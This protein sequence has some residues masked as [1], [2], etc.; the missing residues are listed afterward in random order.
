MEP[1]LRGPIG[2]ETAPVVGS[3]A[4]V[5]RRLD[6]QA[7]S[8][9]YAGSGC[10]PSMAVDEPAPDPGH[11]M[12]APRGVQA[13]EALGRRVPGALEAPREMMVAVGSP[14]RGASV[15]T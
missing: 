5:D 11:V 13:T 6:L 3:A 10:G 14:F 15:V 8:G 12:A 1:A 9:L 7:G 2:D 4:K